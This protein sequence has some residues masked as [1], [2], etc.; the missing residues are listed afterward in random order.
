MVQQIFFFLADSIQFPNPWCFK[1]HQKRK[2]EAALHCFYDNVLDIYE[3][4]GYDLYWV[5]V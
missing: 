1:G 3:H 4:D 5:V 2:K